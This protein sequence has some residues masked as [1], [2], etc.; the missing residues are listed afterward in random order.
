ML[1]F[2]NPFLMVFT[3]FK[4]PLPI[5]L[6][7]L[8]IA[9]LNPNFLISFTKLEKNL[10]TVLIP[11]FVILIKLLTPSFTFS[12]I[13]NSI[14]AALSLNESLSQFFCTY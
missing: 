3:R 12:T 2:A 7:A 13:P 6:K 14:R 9:V 11:D 10:T 4:K 1:A 5:D 8:S